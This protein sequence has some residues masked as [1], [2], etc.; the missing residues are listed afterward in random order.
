LGLIA[1]QPRRGAVL[2]GYFFGPRR[3]H[4]ELTSGLHALT[5]ADAQLVCRFK[6]SGLHRGLWRVVAV[7][8]QWERDPWPVPAF[9][10]KEGLSGR[11][12]RVEYDGDNLMVPARENAAGVTDAHLPEDVVLDE[13]RV[14]E[15]LAKLVQEHRTG[16]SD[17]GQWTG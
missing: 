12:I 9:L 14:V 6:D 11:G 7:S 10:R 8:P 1:R 17:P 2:L 13:E 4:A 3:T 5:S 16:T 15:Q